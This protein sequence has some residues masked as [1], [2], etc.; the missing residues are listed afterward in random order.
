[1]YY[2]ALFLFLTLFDPDEGV[3][4][5]SFPM[6]PFLITLALMSAFCVLHLETK[7]RASFPQPVS[8]A[9]KAAATLTAAFFALMGA[10]QK[11]D[12]GCYMLYAGLLIGASADYTLRYNRTAGVLLFGLGHAVYCA[13]CVILKTPGVANLVTG[14][15]LMLAAL[16]AF[17]LLKKQVVHAT[18]EKPHFIF[19]L[20]M[21]LEAVLIGLSCTLH[22][23]L[24]LG[25]VLFAASDMLLAFKTLTQLDSRPFAYLTLGTYYLAQ[26]LIA[27][28]VFLPV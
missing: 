14:L 22:P 6:I 3:Y 24:L 17:P 12:L 21:L 8:T 2:S 27:V 7:R 23:V 28:C 9:F 5:M 26:L 11:N 13:A 18:G 10:L 16:I 4:I 1:M 15:I 25:A 19:L 20:Y